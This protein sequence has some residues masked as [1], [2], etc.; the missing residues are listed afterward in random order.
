MITC[1]LEKDIKEVAQVLGA[2]RFPRP[3]NSASD[4]HDRPLIRYLA[5]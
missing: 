1:N 3:P 5:G 2:L 4:W